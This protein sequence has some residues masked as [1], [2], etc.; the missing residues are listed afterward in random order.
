MVVG[1]PSMQTSIMSFGHI[2]S[3]IGQTW[4]NPEAQLTGLVGFGQLQLQSHSPPLPGQLHLQEHCIPSPFGGIGPDP[5]PGP[6]GGIGPDPEPIGGIGPDPEPVGGI[7]PDPEPIGGIGPDPEPVGGNGPEPDPVGGIGPDPEP[8]LAGTTTPFMSLAFP[9]FT[10]MSKE[11]TPDSP[12]RETPLASPEHFLSHAARDFG[13][14]FVPAA[15]RSKLQVHIFL[16]TLIFSS[17]NSS[18]KAT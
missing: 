14:S 3:I 8:V 15:M 9:F 16:P 10:D 2:P 13:L 18:Y 6:V 12:V 17:S 5:D 11:N 7:G 1:I 4:V